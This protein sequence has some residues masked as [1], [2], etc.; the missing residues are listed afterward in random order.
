MANLQPILILGNR[1]M[2]VIN[3]FVMTLMNSANPMEG[4]I[5]HL[6]NVF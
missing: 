3:K 1:K 2:V 5:L 4:N 6:Q